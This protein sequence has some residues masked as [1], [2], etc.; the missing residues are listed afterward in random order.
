MPSPEFKRIAS[1][2]NAADAEH[3]KAVLNWNGIDAFL[4]GADLKTSLSYIGTAL[5]DVKLVVRTVD[6]E[7]ASKL[8]QA[9]IQESRDPQTSPWFCGACE[10]VVDAGFDLCWSCGQ[11][12][13]KVEAPFPEVADLASEPSGSD[14]TDPDNALLP[15]ASGTTQTNPY[16]PPLV[17]QMQEPID[18]E[19]NLAQEEAD[20]LVIQSANAAVLG[21]LIPLFGTLY[22]LFLLFAA[23][24]LSWT[25]SPEIRKQIVQSLVVNAVVGAIWLVFLGLFAMM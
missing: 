25:F 5:G 14:T 9:L 21:I 20:D 2:L 24:R 19:A 1:W 23:L 10:E 11:E 12:R 8:L 6:A 3:A 15:P 7:R 18:D 17:R 4:E 13:S 22:S 16:A